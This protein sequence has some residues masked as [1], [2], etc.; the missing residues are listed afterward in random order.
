MYRTSLRYFFYHREKREIYLASTKLKKNCIPKFF[1][2]PFLR[3]QRKAKAFFYQ[4]V[5]QICDY[6]C[7][8]LWGSAG[9]QK[10]PNP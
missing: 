7:L 8:F 1:F 2:Q 5:K 10:S 6:L 9:K 3:A 4:P